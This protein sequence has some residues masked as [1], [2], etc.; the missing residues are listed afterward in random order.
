MLFWKLSRWGYRRHPNKRKKWLNQKYWRTIKNNN[1]CF[2]CT[3]GDMEFTL[4]KHT[5]T[6]I[7]RHIKVKG[8]ASPYDG[9]STYW[10]TRMGKHPEMKASTAR[11]LK[12]QKGKC[13]YCDLTFNPGDKI[14]IDH[15]VPRKAG[16][17]KLKDNLQVIHKHCHD[18][19]TK[20]DLDTI[21]RYKFRKGWDKVYK[22]KN[23]PKA[24]RFLDLALE[25]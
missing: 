18:V 13:N 14:E 4:P 16:G 7:T 10:A 12:K 19:K 5:E 11:L 6:K 25:E 1:W 20:K 21:K 24:L 9:N 17:D 22:T 3:E 15:I 2:S 23:Y 8:E